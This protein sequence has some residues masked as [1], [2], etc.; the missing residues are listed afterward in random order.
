MRNTAV[1][2]TLV[3]FLVASIAIVWLMISG[4]S[5]DRN[6][7][8][9][10][11]VSESI[12]EGVEEDAGAL[13]VD[14]GV[15]E[16]EDRSLRVETSPPQSSATIPRD[17]TATRPPSSATI[18]KSP[19]SSAPVGKFYRTATPTGTTIGNGGL[20]PGTRV[21]VVSEQTDRSVRFDTCTIA[22]SL[23]GKSNMSWAFTAG[24]CGSVGQKVY[25]PPVDGD[26]STAKFLGTIRAVS[27]TD[28]ETRA[29]DW[30]GIRLYANADRPEG[31]SR[32]PLRL[33]TFERPIGETLCKH[34]STTGT[35]CGAKRGEGIRTSLS[36]FSPDTPTVTARM[37]QVA[38][39]ALPGDSGGPVFD[40]MGI[41][42]ILSSS[43]A[44]RSAED[45]RSC[46]SGA[47]AYY[48]PMEDIVKQIQSSLPDV[49]L[50]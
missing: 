23:P 41:V 32:V 11:S 4:L 50:S 19:S 7:A 5:I 16:N 12:P 29:G 9:G 46:E 38:L 36:G 31:A 14:G 34:G 15:I 43:S 30:A 17:P 20:I 48:T 8:Q 6:I 18:P 39:C 44:V 40:K 49:I 25:T 22:F 27:E 42:G 37:D 47:M 33:D 13:N 10:P 1:L 45:P 28:Y 35:D 24:H 21:I 3:V 26:F 2:S